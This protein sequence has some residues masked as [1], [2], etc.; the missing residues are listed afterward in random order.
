M[1]HPTGRSEKRADRAG[2]LPLMHLPSSET[3]QSARRGRRPVPMESGVVSGLL[4]RLRRV[5]DQL[6]HGARRR[7]ALA[8]LAGA[9]RAPESVLVICNGNI[10]RSPFAAAVLRRA[11]E[12]RGLGRV[13]VDSAGFAGPGRAAPADAIAAAARRAIDLSRHASQLVMAVVV[14]APEHLVGVVWLWSGRDLIGL[15]TSDRS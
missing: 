2:A 12:L 5:P 11:L 4:T 6:L 9:E 3:T 7:A 13:R 15:C 8:A 14:R 10:F 1:P